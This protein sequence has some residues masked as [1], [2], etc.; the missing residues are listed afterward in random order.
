M[1]VRQRLNLFVGL[2]TTNIDK[3]KELTNYTRQ[4]VIY[5][6]KLHF[7]TCHFKKKLKISLPILKKD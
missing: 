5:V 1:H 2:G 4:T 7:L 6:D 3:Q